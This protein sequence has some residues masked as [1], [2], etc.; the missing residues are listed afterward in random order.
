MSLTIQNLMKMKILAPK[1]RKALVD[2][3]KMLGKMVGD[4]E[5]QIIVEK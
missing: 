1:N 5:Y 2:D 3:E 4:V